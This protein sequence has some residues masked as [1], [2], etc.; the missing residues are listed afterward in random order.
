M[1]TESINNSMLDNSHCYTIY[2]KDQHINN[3]RDGIMFGM[4]SNNLQSRSIPLPKEFD[5][6]EIAAFV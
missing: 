2:R 5:S 1:L 4:V 6:D 3:V